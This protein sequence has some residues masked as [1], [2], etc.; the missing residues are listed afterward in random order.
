[1]IEYL[2]EECN[3]NVNCES[4]ISCTFSSCYP[5]TAAGCRQKVRGVFK[6]GGAKGLRNFSSHAHFQCHTP[7]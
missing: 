1:M 2:V 4:L 6:V 7:T 5:N 3:V